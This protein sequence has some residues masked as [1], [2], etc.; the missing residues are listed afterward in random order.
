MAYKLDEEDIEIFEETEEG[1]KYLEYYEKFKSKPF[2]RGVGMPNVFETYGTIIN[3]YDECIKQ[4][5][6]WEQLVGDGW[7]ELVE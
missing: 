7:D 3:L 6:R 4:N 2:I 1:K 5:K